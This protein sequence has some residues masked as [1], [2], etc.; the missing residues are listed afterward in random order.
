MT[1]HVHWRESLLQRAQTIMV[2]A[3][4]CDQSIFK[5]T[6]LWPEEGLVEN[7]KISMHVATRQSAC[8]QFWQCRANPLSR[9]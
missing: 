5:Q 6:G 2:E 4:G 8:K 9:Q 3:T 7:L 1:R